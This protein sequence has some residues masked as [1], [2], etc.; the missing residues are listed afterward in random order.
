[1]YAALCLDELRIKWLVQIII[2][3]WSGLVIEWASRTR[4]FIQQM[5]NLKKLSCSSKCC[6]MVHIADVWLWTLIFVSVQQDQTRHKGRR[7]GTTTYTDGCC[8]GKMTRYTAHC[9]NKMVNI[10]QVD[11]NR[12]PIAGPWGRGMGY[13]TWVQNLVCVLPSPLHWCI[14]S[15]VIFDWVLIYSY[16]L[17]CWLLA[18]CL[19][20]A[21]WGRGGGGFQKRV[22]ALKS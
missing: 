4:I 6:I 14:D 15:Y 10:L 22:W 12:R 11:S 19:S 18:L 9:C 20:L 16:E 3:A 17:Y 13:L 1:M 7:L 5:I 2:L 21:H 8:T